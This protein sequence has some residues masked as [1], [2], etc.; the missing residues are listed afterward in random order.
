MPKI[1]LYVKPTCSTCRQAVQIVKESGQEFEAVPYFEKRFTKA[2]L[3]ELVD[4]L[5]LPA[6]ELLRT[7]EDT[8]KALKVEASK[9]SPGEVVDL[10]LKHP[11]LIQ[12]PIAEKGGKVI[13]ARPSEKVRELL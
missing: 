2:K 5:G 9:L 12:R 10:M 6:P 3:R 8:F 4:K 1:T 11:E 7:K 13:L